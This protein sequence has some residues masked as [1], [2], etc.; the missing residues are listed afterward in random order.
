MLYVLPEFLSLFYDVMAS[1]VSMLN[2]F[3]FL[4]FLFHLLMF[5]TVFYEE[6]GISSKISRCLFV[7][8]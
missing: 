4:L 7:V 5:N 2:K 3:S 1:L 6:T 8:A